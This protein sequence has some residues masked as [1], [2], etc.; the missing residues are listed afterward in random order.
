[1]NNIIFGLI[2]LIMSINGCMAYL[3]TDNCDA[4]IHYL[5]GQEVSIEVSIEPT[6]ETPMTEPR[7]CK[8]GVRPD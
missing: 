2:L 4:E 8:L 5:P 7:V 3:H 6:V 1:M